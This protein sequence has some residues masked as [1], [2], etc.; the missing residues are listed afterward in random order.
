MKILI[1]GA[2]GFIGQALA[3]RLLDSG[4]DVFGIDIR[5][6]EAMPDFMKQNFKQL[7]IL[8]VQGLD[9]LFATYEPNVVLHL[10][11]ML[12]HEK[13]D[14]K[15]F[16]DTNEG[17]TQN[18]TELCEKYSVQKLIFLS[19]N[20]IW[21]E[22]LHELVAE[23]HPYSFVEKYGDS[24]ARC[25]E[26]L[27][28]RNSNL[29]ISIFRAPI[30]MGPQRLGLFGLLFEF[31]HENKR[32]Y[33][34]GSGINTVQIL[35]I[36][37][38]V[39]ALLLCV[40]GRFEGVFNLGTSFNYSYRELLDYLVVSTNSKSRIVSIPA[41]FVI[42]LLKILNKLG[43]SP[44]GPYQYLTLVNNFGMNFEKFQAITGWAPVVDPKKSLFDSFQ[45]W[46]K[47]SQAQALNS[48]EN[49]ANMVVPKSLIYRIV[50]LL[51]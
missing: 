1:T 5:A 51:S 6:G 12:G 45:D 47:K 48:Q 37:D 23:D 34:V 40:E 14:N 42:P 11:S 18:I 8:N 17:G 22:D 46:K 39:D 50:K 4:Y 29:Q 43:L 31:I 41:F 35:S 36:D 20:S 13:S 26:Y 33:T 10:A 9:D 49:S 16:W 21:C 27:M 24:K 7:D 28:S 32:L 19:S 3:R 15:T 2:N 25:E 44:I 38:L 30:I